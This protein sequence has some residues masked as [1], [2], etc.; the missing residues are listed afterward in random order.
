MKRFLYLLRHAKSSWNYPELNDF[1]RPLNKRGH[2]DAPLM[3]GVIKKLDALPDLIVSSPAARAAMTAK[4][5]SELLQIDETRL[6][7][8]HR[9]YEAS[10]SDLLAII[11]QTDNSVNRLMIVGHNPG[12][13]TFA[14]FLTGH[15][16]ENIPTAGF[17]AI[18]LL[19]DN[20]QKLD[21]NGGRYL[22]IKTP[23]VH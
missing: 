15:H 13:T 2:R 10:P 21:E 7:F 18:E 3:A 9:I 11:R 6:H 1:E 14:R 16:I 22:F 23:K 20:W 17:Y 12:L 5:V 4:I 8:N 19:A